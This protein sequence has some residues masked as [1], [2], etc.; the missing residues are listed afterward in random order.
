[1]LRSINKTESRRNLSLLLS[2]GMVLGLALLV[3]IT[4]CQTKPTPPPPGCDADAFCDDG[5][6]C[7]GAETCDVESGDCVDGTPP[8]EE[9]LCVEEDDMC[10]ECLE[11]ADCTDDGNFCTGDPVCNE[12]NTCGFTGDPCEEG[13]TCNEDEDRCEIQE[14]GDFAA[15]NPG[16][17]FDAVVAGEEI[18]LNAPLP[19]GDFTA[20]QVT[21]TFVGWAVNGAGT[22]DPVDATPTMYTPAADDT[23]ITVTWDCGG[24]IYVLAVDITITT[25]QPCE[26]DDECDDGLFCNGIEVCGTNGFCADGELPCDAETET[27][28][29]GDTAAEC[30]PIEVECREFTLGQDTLRGTSANDCFDAGLEFNSGTGT[31]ISTFQNGDSA[32][33]LAGYDTLDV[34]LGG[35]FA[36][37]NTIT[38]TLT[39]IEEVNITDFTN[40]TGGPFTQTLAGANWTG[41]QVVNSVSSG[42]TAAAADALIVNNLPALVDIGLYGTIQDF[43]VGFTSDAT[44][45]LD[46]AMTLTL[47][48]TTALADPALGP[49]V[50]ITEGGANGIETLNIVSIGTAA[51][52]VEDIVLAQTTLKTINISGDQNLAIDLPLDNNVLTVNCAV[53][54]DVFEGNLTE[55][56]VGNGNVAFTG[57]NGDDTVIYGANYTAAD[58]INGGLGTD[59]L[60]LTDAV[61]APATDQTNVTNI[62]R[63]RLSDTL[64]AAPVLSRWGSINGVTLDVG[65]NAGTLTFPTGTGTAAVICGARAA[66][67]D[68]AG[69]ATVAMAGVLATDV[70]N[71]TLNDSDFAAALTITGAETVNVASNLDLDGSAADGGGVNVVAGVTTITPTAG[72]ATLNISGT[73]D[74]TF[75]GAINGAATINATGFANVLTLTAGPGAA[76]TIT[77]GDGNDVLNGSGA[78]D[79]INGGAGNDTINGGGGADSIAG[80][81]GN[82]TFQFDTSAATDLISD[83]TDGSDIVAISSTN[84]D[85]AGGA[86]LAQGGGAAASLAATAAGA[87]VL[88]EVAQNAAGSGVGTAQFIKLTTP[89]AGAA[90]DQL[91]FN[92][93]IGTATV[94]GLTAGTYMAGSFYNTTDGVMVLFEVN[95]TAGTNTQIETADV[96]AVIAK[97]T[98]TQTA[99]TNFTTSDLSFVDM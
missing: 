12:D 96:I 24:V 7:N 26:T 38:V 72:T 41:A 47:S 43:T 49:T 82:D 74:L 1:M 40:D 6:F 95:A 60:G 53:T 18:E 35:V 85:F 87:T 2:L 68:S 42:G 16:V 56:T 23:E 97:I 73:E 99:Y 79:T 70:V 21:C 67:N 55:L 46:D 27:C 28:E 29:E 11:D 75:T 66:D 89:V 63:I 32:E 57:G 44:S 92:A 80:G 45:A 69:A 77:G 22:F 71:L 36:A 5:V 51:N 13:E 88:K 52:A 39:G 17:N 10:L 83:W 9:R 37:N 59:T 15:A 90:T 19:A 34:V 76:A 8:C 48:A 50:T 78:N 98:M 31:Q 54:D 58:T 62:E 93:A 91:T 14:A 25:A 84:T 3:G 30:I 86:G 20:A 33:G 94:T 81:T 65:F 4:G 64:T 61:V